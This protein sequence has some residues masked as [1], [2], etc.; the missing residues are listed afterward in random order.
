MKNCDVLIIGGGPSGAIA[1]ANLVQKGFSVEIIEKLDFPRFV[2]GES[3][4][5]HCNAIL[6]KNNLLEKI[7]KCGYILKA[8]ASFVNEQGEEETYHFRENLGEEHNTSFQVKREEFDH[9]LLK[10]ASE[11]GAHVQHGVEVTDYD[12]TSNV[13]T[14]LDKEGN[15]EQYQAQ[16]V[17]D[18]SGYGRVLP[19]LLDLDIP[20]DLKTR[21]AVFTRVENDIRPEGE[22][23]GYITI[24][25]HGDNDAWVWVIPFADGTTSVGI[26]STEEYFD[27]MNLSDEAFWD[28]IIYSN[29]HTKKRFKN[30]KKLQ[31]VDKINGYSANVKTMH[32]KGFV[33]AG[34]ATEFLDPVFSSGVTLALVSGDL[35]ADLI[36]KELNGEKVNWQT[37]YQ[38][39]MMVG[40]DVFRAFVMAWYDGRLHKILF[41]PIKQDMHTRSVS[42]ILSGYVW[43]KKNVFVGQTEEK[44][45]TLIKMI[46]ANVD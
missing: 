44:I 19:R 17:L 41:S 12:Q 2:I 31:A 1:G 20:S 5:P 45:D 28:H 3:L 14:T 43:N 40:V 16:F 15:K 8:G 13:V 9:E 35:A 25:I 30:A 27:K 42:S 26:V 39:Y 24:Y 4:L 21:Q 23:S 11:F 7:E 32:G 46:Y 22:L 38:D 36:A 10:G 18:A 34:N 33:L 29:I 37:E 6:A